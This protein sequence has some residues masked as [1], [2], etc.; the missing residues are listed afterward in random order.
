MF[1]EREQPRSLAFALA[2]AL[3]HEIVSSTEKVGARIFDPLECAGPQH[4]RVL[5]HLL[6]RFEQVGQRAFLLFPQFPDHVGNEDA[7]RFQPDVIVLLPGLGDELLRDAIGVG[8]MRDLGEWRPID[9][10][11]IERIEDDV[12][13]LGPEVSRRSWGSLMAGPPSRRAAGHKP[14]S[15]RR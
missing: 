15:S 12:A 6:Q 1:I 10:A 3:D 4:A 14:R 11:G 5:V 9:R 7:A 13:A 8:G 2:C